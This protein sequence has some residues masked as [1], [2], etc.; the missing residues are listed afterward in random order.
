[1]QIL[2]RW[3]WDWTHTLHLLELPDAAG[4]AGLQ[5]TASSKAPLRSGLAPKAGDTCFQK[6]Q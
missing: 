2:I 4:A 3:G 6:E 1:M 5:T